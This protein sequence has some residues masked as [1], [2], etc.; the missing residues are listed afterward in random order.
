MKVENKGNRTGIMHL[1]HVH[2]TRWSHILKVFAFFGRIGGTSPFH[3]EFDRSYRRKNR[4]REDQRE[5]KA[6]VLRGIRTF[7]HTQ[8]H[9]TAR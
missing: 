2:Q 8:G 7:T 4:T 3:A 1:Y 9:A 5:V 6:L